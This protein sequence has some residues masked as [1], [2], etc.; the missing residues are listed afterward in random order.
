MAKFRDVN[1]RIE[2]FRVLERNPITRKA[3]FRIL[4]EIEAAVPVLALASQQWAARNILYRLHKNHREYQNRVLDQKNNSDA[5]SGSAGTGVGVP[6]TEED[7]DEHRD[8]ESPSEKSPERSNVKK[9]KRKEVLARS[10][11]EEEREKSTLRSV[12]RAKKARLALEDACAQ[13]KTSGGSRRRGPRFIRR[14]PATCM[15]P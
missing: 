1:G 11:S 13:A 7:G 9:R 10:D 2:S 15:D 3:I 4:D 12:Q 5:C 14:K 8:E 6:T